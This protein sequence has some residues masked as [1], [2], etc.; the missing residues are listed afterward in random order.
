MITG[1]LICK[2]GNFSVL[3]KYR[4]NPPIGDVVGGSYI[5][6]PPTSYIHTFQRRFSKKSSSGVF[7]NF[8]V[9]ALHFSQFG[10]F[11]VG[12][13]QV[14]KSVHFLSKNVF[15]RFI[16]IHGG[17]VTSGFVA[18]TKSEVYPDS[19]VYKYVPLSSTR[20]GSY[21]YGQSS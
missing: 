18:R 10:D 3:K 19:V 13:L 5:T 8:R 2:P 7:R 9:G 12:V 20:E 15:L 14:T 1:S 17:G 16:T 21:Y 4:K 11:R 6:P